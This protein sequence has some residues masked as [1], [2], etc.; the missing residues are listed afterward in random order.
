MKKFFFITSIFSLILLTAIIK[1]ST[2]EIEDEIFMTKENL[3]VLE[4][5]FGN[6][7][8]EFDYLSSSKKLFNYQSIYFENELS[9]KNINEIKMI[10]KD[11]NNILIYNFDF[12]KKND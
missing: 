11:E 6:L 4:S 10:K 8:L 9:K 2:K 1:N 12:Q 7:S 3:R 5:E